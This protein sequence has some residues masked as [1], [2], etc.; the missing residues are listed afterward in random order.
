MYER[1]MTW[2]RYMA[3]EIEYDDYVF[4][5]GSNTCVRC[6]AVFTDENPCC[7]SQGCNKDDTLQIDG[8]CT[9]CCVHPVR[10]SYY[11]Q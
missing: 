4:A 11:N 5:H 10:R 8:V 2:V 9:R 7:C 3:G 1:Q 6:S